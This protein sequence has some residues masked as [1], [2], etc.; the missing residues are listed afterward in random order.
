[1]DVKIKSAWR[2]RT[3]K[4]KRPRWPSRTRRR[5]PTTCFHR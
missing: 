5:G 3:R 2:R 1:M 4:S